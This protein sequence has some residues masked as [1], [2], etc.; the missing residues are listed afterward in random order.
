MKYKIIGVTGRKYNGKDTIANY[1]NNKY[2][3]DQNAFAQ[4]LKEICKTLFNFNQEQ[5]YGTLKETP[6]PNWFNLTPRQVFQFV[7]TDLFRNKMNNLSS[8]FENNFWI[9]CMENKIKNSNNYI[10]ISDVRFPNEVEM[11]KKLGGI[12]IRVNRPNLENN[13]LSNHPSET[14]IDTLK[15][16]FDVTNDSTLDALYLKI[17]NILC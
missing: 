4:P 14:M 9:K 13:E 12:I 3:Y 16:D 11:I 10:V 8:E 6:D 7:G 17:D 15:V 5:L 1:L 2:D